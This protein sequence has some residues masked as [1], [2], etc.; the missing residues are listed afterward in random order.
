MIIPVLLYYILFHYGPMY[1]AMIAFK[2]FSPGKGIW[3]SPWIGLDNFARFINGVYFERLIKNT[4]TINI[5]NLLFGFPAPILLAL[6]F[7]EMRAKHFKKVVQ[8]ASY[9][10]HFVSIMVICGMII[11][12][13]NSKGVINDLI[14][15]LGGTRSSLMLN[16]SLF[17][18]IYVITDI[19]Q[20][21]GWN[22]IIFIA[23][24]SS[25]DT[26]IYEAAVIDGAGRF[27][28]ALHVTLP[29][30]AP[31]IIILLILRIGQMMNVGF[32]KIILLYNPTTYTT[33]DVI[34]SFVYREG[35]LNFSFSFSAAVGLFNSLINFTLIL[36]A[37]FFSRKF[38]ETSLW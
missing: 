19:W 20:E 26:Q 23:A 33:A 16:A 2:N 14:A 37:N 11:D 9:L 15:L 18:P 4:L 27:K 24:M 12:F 34:S 5:M 8:T 21:V 35:M 3:G 10:P 30:I 25:I 32:E 29:G 17:K 22:S 1:G 36:M 13:T 38:T 28:Q 31:T 7:N 6:L